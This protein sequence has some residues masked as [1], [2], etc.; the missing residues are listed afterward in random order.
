M[1]KQFLFFISL[2]LLVS[3]GG[4]ES[5]S[6][7]KASDVKSIARVW[8]EALLTAIRNDEARPPVHA[9]NLYHLSLA[10][11]DLWAYFDSLSTTYFLGKSKNSIDCPLEKPL[12][13]DEDI[14]TTYVN[15]MSY[16]A[17]TLLSERFKNSPNVT[18]TMT[19]LDAI[20]KNN[21]LEANFSNINYQQ[22][23][24]ALGI[25][26]ANCI[27]ELGLAD[28][29]NESNNYSNKFYEPINE[30]LVLAQSGNPRVNNPNRWQPLTFEEFIGQ[31]GIPSDDNT[32]G[33][34]GAEWGAVTPFALTTTNL[35]IKQDNG[36][37]Y[38]VYHDPS[39]P[40]LLG[41]NTDEAYKWNFS[42]VS[43]WSSHLDT[44][45]STSWDIS[46]K[47][48]GNINSDT[49]PNT[50]REF[51]T[52]YN[53]LGSNTL[54]QGYA[55]NPITNS[56]YEENTVPRADY[57]RVIAEF[58]ADGPDSETPPGHWF[59]ILNELVSDKIEQKQING[60]IVDDLEWD[61]KAYFT[62]GGA[63]HDAAIAAWGIKG[64]Y[65]Y[66]RP[67]SAI[68]YMA[69]Q[70][71]SSDTSL[72]NYDFRG[73]PLTKGLVE[74]ISEDDPLAEGN[75]SNIGKIKLYTWR[76]HDAIDE[77]STD[78]A[79]VDWILAEDWWPYQRPTF[80]TPP[81]AGYVSGHSTFS[82]AAA[83]VLSQLTGSEYFPNGMGEYLAPKD[84]FLVFERGPSV[85]VR[86]Q[87]ATYKDAADQSAL[88]RIWGGIHPPADDIPGRR[89]GKKVGLDAYAQAEGLWQAN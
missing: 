9:R 51:Q 34:I 32:P 46:P 40:P 79:G 65:D 64:W 1:H 6:K 17:Y 30:P 56:A 47:S 20:M 54:T 80:V 57:A 19:H 61:V 3:C 41:S 83:V 23:S 48:L 70:G 86:L 22:S 69:G 13:Y 26:F 2:T 81:F 75:S 71:Q 21:S 72:S 42:L 52:F 4:G 29:S 77:P 18:T 36:S 58:W 28:N 10:F 78:V 35:T 45:D 14:Q 60:V 87:W 24:S 50:L 31:S 74:V 73:I 76:G 7:P 53:S 59:V 25:Y 49:Y 5:G 63:M 88:S 38:Y 15:S 68:R 27:I 82:A 84:N 55:T 85:D 89:I 37:D 43:Q 33:F 8:N 11:Y 62:L 39:S 44:S 66:I 67:I 16:A 12:H